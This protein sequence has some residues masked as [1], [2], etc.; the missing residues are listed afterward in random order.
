MRML[1]SNNFGNVTATDTVGK[2]GP[3]FQ[4]YN[5]ESS[6]GKGAFYQNRLVTDAF[7]FGWGNYSMVTHHISGDSLYLVKVGGVAYQFW[8]KKYTSNPSDSINYEF[9]IAKLDGTDDNTVKIF[10]KSA[11]GD[12]TNRLFAYYDVANNTIVNHEPSPR[13]GW[14]LMFTQYLSKVPGPGGVMAYYPVTGV[15]TNLGTEVADIR[16]VEPNS[17]TSANYKPYLI[18]FN[19]KYTNEIGADWKTY[20]QGT[21]KYTMDDSGSFIVKSVNTKEYWQIHFT[22]F[23]GGSPA[24]AGKIEFRKRQLGSAVAV[25]AIAAKAVTAW[26]VSP[27]PAANEATLMLDAKKASTAQLV[28]TDMAGRTVQSANLDI[29]AGLNAFN[30]NTANWPAGIYAVQVAAAD[31]KMSNRL[32]VAH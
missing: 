17:I 18:Q 26:S 24:G 10:R 2:T 32:V 31:W 8:P 27:N 21:F 5:D 22:R 28:I 25:P 3:A 9:R 16:H 6:W 1:A 20:N 23:D 12:Y 13:S 15:L 4:L 19:T 14:D 30:L 11:T 7:S 29:K